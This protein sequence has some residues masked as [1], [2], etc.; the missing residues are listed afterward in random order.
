M[1]TLV[2]RLEVRLPPETLRLLRQEAAQR[3]LPVSRL[4]REAIEQLLQEDRQVRL[5]AA[6]A[7]FEVGAPVAAWTKMKREIERAR[8]ASS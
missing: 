3:G 8:L 5:R 2:E 6:Q 1:A 4:V 7:L